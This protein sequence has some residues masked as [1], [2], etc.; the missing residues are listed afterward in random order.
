MNKLEIIGNIVRDPESRDVAGD[1]RVCN[2]TVAC[3]RKQK[4]QNGN[5]IADFFRISAWGK[6]GE[7][8]QKYLAKGRKVA[9]VG[10]VSVHPYTD[11]EGNAKAN[12][13][14]FAEEVE[15]LSPA[16]QQ[17]QQEQTATAAAPAPAPAPAAYTEVS[18]EDL[19]F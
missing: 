9:V 12:L 7:N 3:N 13:E 2:F 6:M 16:G 4:D 8:C 15:F 19:P 1:K 18:T 10:S 17:G 14:V 11:S 5:S